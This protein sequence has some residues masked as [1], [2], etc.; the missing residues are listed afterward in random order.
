MIENKKNIPYDEGIRTSDNA[1]LKENSEVK[2]VIDDPFRR[3]VRAAS[4]YG[5]E[6]FYSNIIAHIAERFPLAFTKALREAAGNE[7]LLPNGFDNVD[8]EFKRFDLTFSKRFDPIS[9]APGEKKKR[10][11]LSE[12]P[13]SIPQLIIENKSG[14]I[15][16][17]SQLQNYSRSLAKT[18]Y[19]QAHSLNQDIM[20]EEARRDAQSKEIDPE[21]VRERCILLTPCEYDAEIAKEAGWSYM[22]YAA[23]AQALLQAL[24]SP[25]DLA[26]M[27]AFPH[28][29]EYQFLKEALI[30]MEDLEKEAKKDY[31]YITSETP[32]DALT[33]TDSDT[34][35]PKN[36]KRP[37]TLDQMKHRYAKLVYLLDCNFKEDAR[38]G[39]YVK[40]D[41]KEFECKYTTSP[42]TQPIAEFSIHNII[43]PSKDKDEEGEEPLNFYC[44]FQNGVLT[45]GFAP[46]KTNV[47]AIEG[48]QK[49]GEE[50]KIKQ[51]LRKDFWNKFKLGEVMDEITCEKISEKEYAGSGYTTDKYNMA[52]WKW[53]KEEMEGQTVA[54]IIEKMIGMAER[55]FKMK[56]KK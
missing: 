8:R 16:Y 17:V 6:L 2:N 39:R 48:A 34:S 10:R 21:W 52:I 55:A 31:D 50:R 24:E 53:D 41:A 44:A 1:P 27:E 51:G 3:L 43:L 54:D 25:E 37:I 35:D 5:R 15:S 12:E 13:K 18:V 23:F 33:D 9:F 56:Y 4:G 29:P 22:G 45:A 20:A 28:P 36:H 40:E 47:A 14:S 19:R 32:I 26:N 11:K 38:V 42:K 7:N 46:K 49:K 30:Y